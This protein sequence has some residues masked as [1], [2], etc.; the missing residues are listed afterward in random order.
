MVKI[1]TNSGFKMERYERELIETC[2]KLVKH[3]LFSLKRYE[4]EQI[5]QRGT[6]VSKTQFLEFYAE[7]C[8]KIE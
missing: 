3:S 4:R 1:S 2:E 5:N 7:E 8:E 6:I